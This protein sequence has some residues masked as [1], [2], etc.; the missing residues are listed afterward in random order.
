MW[1]V[2][3]TFFFPST[4]VVGT[5]LPIGSGMVD[6]QTPLPPLQLGIV[7]KTDNCRVNTI[8]F[9]KVQ[10]SIFSQAF[11]VLASPPPLP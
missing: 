6:V 8:A 1:L 2:F 7:S 4:F 11:Q 9:C 10:V 3:L 5:G